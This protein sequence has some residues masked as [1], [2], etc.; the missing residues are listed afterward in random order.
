MVLILTSTVLAII[1]LIL[2]TDLERTAAEGT[3]CFIGDDHPKAVYMWIAYIALIMVTDMAYLMLLNYLMV[4]RLLRL[5]SHQLQMTVS[6]EARKS[7]AS[8]VQIHRKN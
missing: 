7:L 5:V 4:N 6:V 2:S 1:T 3:Y 8:L